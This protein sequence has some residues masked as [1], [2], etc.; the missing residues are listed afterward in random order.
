MKPYTPQSRVGTTILANA[1]DGSLDRAS[2][3]K[4][5]PTLKKREGSIAARKCRDWLIWLGGYPTK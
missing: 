3:S 4:M 1:I 2:L 5:L